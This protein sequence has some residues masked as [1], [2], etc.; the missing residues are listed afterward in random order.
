MKREP[1]SPP[2][3][4]A[5]L[6][7]LPADIAA[8]AQAIPG[9]AADKA[10]DFWR[11]PHTQQLVQAGSALFKLALGQAEQLPYPGPWTMMLSTI[12][13]EQ[14]ICPWNDDE[15]PRAAHLDPDWMVR[16]AADVDTM[17]RD[18]QSVRDCTRSLAKVMA[19]SRVAATRH[20]TPFLRATVAAGAAVTLIRRAMT[21]EEADRRLEAM[22]AT[23]HAC[24]LQFW[25]D[26]GGWPWKPIQIDPRAMF[27]ATE[28]V[29]AQTGIAAAVAGRA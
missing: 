15:G 2:P 10:P 7:D 28:R 11:G 1:R 22:L 9:P 20:V 27:L 19:L 3:L 23:V 17:A 29:A 6:R 13:G 26:H 12:I 8:E 25:N 18:K 16:L 14:G 4:P 5:W 21:E 24:D